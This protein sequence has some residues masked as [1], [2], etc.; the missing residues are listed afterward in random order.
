MGVSSADLRVAAGVARWECGL[1]FARCLHL[2]ISNAAGSWRGR[3]SVDT[4]SGRCGGL[5][6]SRCGIDER[7]AVWRFAGMSPMLAT[8]STIEMTK[9]APSDDA[10]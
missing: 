3:S 9:G 6:S 7:C 5:S 2:G 1:S 8:S 4:K 10:R